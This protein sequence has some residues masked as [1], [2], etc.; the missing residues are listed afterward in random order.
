MSL[1]IQ[2]FRYCEIEKVK[3]NFTPTTKV[4]LNYY[5]DVDNSKN[6]KKSLLYSVFNWID[7]DKPTLF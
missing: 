3:V 7:L 1:K 4:S 6:K 2:R 5:D